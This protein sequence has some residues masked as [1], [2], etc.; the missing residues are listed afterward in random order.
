MRRTVIPRL[1]GLLFYS[2]HN[3]IPLL[4]D[5][6]KIRIQP[7]RRY[8]RRGWTGLPASTPNSLPQNEA[9][10]IL[11]GEADG[12]EQTAA[13]DF[14]WLNLFKNARGMGPKSPVVGELPLMP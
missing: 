11:Y 1:S 14:E 5:R 6:K 12:W 7:P 4:K 13:D 10:L 8:S 3:L 9:R 2:C